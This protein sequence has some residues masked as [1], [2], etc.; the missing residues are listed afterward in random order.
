MGEIKDILGWILG[1]SNVGE[2]WSDSNELSA[3]WLR[4]KNV[5]RMGHIEDIFK[6]R[7]QMKEK[8]EKESKCSYNRMQFFS[9][10]ERFKIPG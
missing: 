10:K 4:Q 2:N 5:D 1:K 7:I 6:D 8:C 9:A 3:E